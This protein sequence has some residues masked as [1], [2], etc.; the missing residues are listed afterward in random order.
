MPFDVFGLRDTV[1]G[2]Y[3]GYFESS[4]YQA[5][6]GKMAGKESLYPMRFAVPTESPAGSSE[7]CS[8]LYPGI[9]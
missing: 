5:T 6:P 7:H 9:S 8:A 3:A 4:E 1:V 2:E